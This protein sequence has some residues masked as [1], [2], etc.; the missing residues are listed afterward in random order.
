MLRFD[1]N[2]NRI[3]V[4]PIVKKLDQIEGKGKTNMCT[5]WITFVIQEAIGIAQAFVA[6]SSIKPGEKTAL[7]NLITA[8]QAAITAIQA[9]V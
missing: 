7:E 8:G 4:G 6:I 9:G 2:A 5:F 1:S 3:V